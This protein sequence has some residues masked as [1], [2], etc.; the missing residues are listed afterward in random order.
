MKPTLLGVVRGASLH[1]PH[2]REQGAM[3]GSGRVALTFPERCAMVRR[4]PPRDPTYT[5]RRL[6]AQRRRGQK[7][8][9]AGHP[10]VSALG[11]AKPARGRRRRCDAT[12]APCATEATG[13]RPSGSAHQ[14]PAESGSRAAGRVA[15]LPL[16]QGCPPLG[17]PP[18][19]AGGPDLPQLP[20]FLTWL[21][22]SP[23]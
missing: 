21:Q 8:C 9:W 11:R 10:R 12:T 14:R 2:P 6:L 18:S 1:P 23:G 4:P 17:P 20:P 22:F 16:P 19:S 3:A 13:A 5:G 15:Q 7:I